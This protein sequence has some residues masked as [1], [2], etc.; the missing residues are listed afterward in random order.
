MYL[1]QVMVPVQTRHS[2][3]VTDDH[4]L[5]T[6]LFNEVDVWRWDGVGSVLLNNN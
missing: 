2:Y 1:V 5:Q 3:G 4:N 6:C